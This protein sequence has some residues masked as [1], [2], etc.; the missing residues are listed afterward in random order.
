MRFIFLLLLTSSCV[1]RPYY[2]GEKSD[3][4]D[5]T[6]FIAEDKPSFLDDLQFAFSPKTS[7]KKSEIS[8]ALDPKKNLNSTIKKARLIFIGHS[9]FLIQ[10]PNLNI[11]TD[12]IWSERA[13]PIALPIFSAKRHHA[14]ALS[15][16]ELPKID[17]VFISHSSYYHMDLPTI[18][19]LQKAF[20]PQ[21]ITGLGNCHYLNDVKKLDLN[22]VELDWNQRFVANDNSE[23]FFL[24]TK[25]W[26]KRS[27]VDTNK[28]LW[29]SLLIKTPKI[30]IY[31]AGDTGYGKHLSEIG[32]KFG[33]I[34]VALLPIG[35]YEP[36]WYLQD[37][38][39]NPQDAVNAHL[40]LKAKLSIG[41][42]FN[43]FQTTQEGYLDVEKDLLTAKKIHHLEDKNFVVPQ[44]GESFGF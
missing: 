23:F 36:R 14:P 21:F 19:N 11:I 22:C 26:S 2:S 3:H 35:A 5:G 37:H 32:E 9:T 38:H 16:T 20:A 24:P 39:M 30:K 31:F 13:G 18:R 29:G 27:Y 42:H 10:L 40:A 6:R 17:I 7:W 44:F 25:G 12:P 43:T 33:R 41:M 4:F 8:Q 34:D 15:I 1:L 28:T